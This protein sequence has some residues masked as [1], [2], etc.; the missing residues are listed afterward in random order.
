MAAWSR[1]QWFEGHEGK[2]DHR[3]RG[4]QEK[5][6]PQVLVGAGGEGYGCRGG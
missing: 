2:E 3:L 4:L 6:S 1:V 5:E